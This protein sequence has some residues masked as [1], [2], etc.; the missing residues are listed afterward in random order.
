M[1]LSFLLCSRGQKS[2]LVDAMAVRAS[3]WIYYIGSKLGNADLIHTT[4]SLSALP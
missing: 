1:G 2:S 4:E 3:G